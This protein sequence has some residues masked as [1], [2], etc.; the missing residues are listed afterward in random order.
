V[1]AS[2]KAL[3]RSEMERGSLFG[4]SSEAF[5]RREPFEDV[6]GLRSGKV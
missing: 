2:P 4:R 6:E 5:S 1:A 3:Q